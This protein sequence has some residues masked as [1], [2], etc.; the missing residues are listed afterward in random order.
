ML[1]NFHCTLLLF[2]ILPLTCQETETTNKA[3]DDIRD[4]NHKVM[5][6]TAIILFTVLV[7]YGIIGNALMMIV[8]LSSRRSNHY[9]HSFVLIASQLIIS[10]LTS[11][12]PQVVVVLPEL[13]HSKN[14]PYG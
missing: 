6:Y 8:L 5:R 2:L 12:L 3:N 10:N 1:T 11:F 9:S 4:E 14:S 7:L 13:L